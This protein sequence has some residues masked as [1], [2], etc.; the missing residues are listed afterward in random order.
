[1]FYLI[2]KAFLFGISISALV[3]PL[4]FTM[5]HSGMRFG[6]KKAIWL[7][8]GTWASDL[9]LLLISYYLISR[10]SLPNSLEEL[11]Y[12]IVWASSILLILL[13]LAIIIRKTKLQENHEYTLKKKSPSYLAIKG[14]IINTV[15]PAAFFIWLG[16]A[17]FIRNTTSAMTEVILFYTIVVLVI[18]SMDICKLVLGQFLSNKLTDQTIEKFKWISGSAFVAT[19]IL[20]LIRYL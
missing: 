14:F 12:R 18:G 8:I 20:L 1:M 10:I 17:A 13:G 4:L 9:F 3:G 11:D 5:I 7:A 16:L 15:N 6:Y 19:G 2:L